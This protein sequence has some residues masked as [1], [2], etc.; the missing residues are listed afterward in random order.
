MTDVNTDNTDTT[1]IDW[2]VI[3]NR[4]VLY[5][6]KYRNL[7]LKEVVCSQ[8]KEDKVVAKVLGKLLKGFYDVTKHEA[9]AKDIEL[10]YK[11]EEE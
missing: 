4:C 2:S 7:M 9:S 11:E 10:I 8:V 6:D 1:D 3:H 5:I